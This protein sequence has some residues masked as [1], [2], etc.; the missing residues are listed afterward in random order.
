[1]K[2]IGKGYIRSNQRRA[3]LESKCMMRLLRIFEE[4]LSFSFS[5]PDRMSRVPLFKRPIP[6]AR[7]R[8]FHLVQFSNHVLYQLRII[9]W[10][11]NQHRLL[12]RSLISVPRRLSRHDRPQQARQSLFTRSSA[13]LRNH[14]REATLNTRIYQ[15]V[16]RVISI[17]GMILV[18]LRQ[19][20]ANEIARWNT[21]EASSTMWW[22]S[23]MWS[24]E[25]AFPFG[26]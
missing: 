17:P 2:S 24:K 21:P 13:K 25:D 3:R 1:M 22:N 10:S 26:E 14:F 8:S 7:S 18:R 20:F 15:R 9:V 16:R 5:S 11:T 23:G 19:K 6:S 12:D 4:A